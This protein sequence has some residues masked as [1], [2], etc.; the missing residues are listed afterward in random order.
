MYFSDGNANNLN[1]SVGRAV[2]APP[3]SQSVLPARF[4]DSAIRARYDSALTTP[5][6]ARHWRSADPL[7]ADAAMNF[8]VRK[9]I[10][11]RAR[12]EIANNTY[13]KGLVLTFASDIIGTGPRIQLRSPLNSKLSPK[14][15]TR[16][17][18]AFAEWAEETCLAEKLT[19]L[20]QAKTGDGEAFGLMVYNPALESPVKFELVPIECD[21]ITASFEMNSRPNCIDG[22]IIDNIGN[23]VAYEYMEEHPGD[24][25]STKASL[26]QWRRVDA[27]WVVHWFRKDRPE[28]HRGISEIAPALPLFAQL[29]RYTLATIAAAETAADYAA[30]LYTDNPAT[31]TAVKAVPFDCVEIAK[32]T[33]TVL[34]DGWKMGQFNPEQP[35]TTYAEFKREVLGEIARC[36]QVPVNVISGDSSH[37]NYAS[38]RLDHQTYHRAIRVN[39]HQC[40]R[41]VLNKLFREWIKEYSLSLGQSDR[42]FDSLK[43]EWFF[44][45]FEH[46][47]PKKEADAQ[48]VRLASLTT[49]LAR[50]YAKQGL[51][52][53]VELEQIARERAKMKELGIAMEEAVPNV[54]EKE[55]E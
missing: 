30:I 15:E 11:E 47:D 39:Q 4:S 35:V 53:E 8:Q 37:H 22:V 52:W 24:T 28:Q 12:Y 20:A 6:N 54:Q 49:G 17:E 42:K 2:L 48:A 16:I 5:E 55:D 34:P 3:S 9:T 10:R 25:S 45:G 43:A 50:E 18:T 33:M 46:V 26:A 51:D 38:G 44:D 29:R 36:L 32:R 14:W 13:A 19:T 31:Q 23:P 1:I 41:V 21:R 40:A 27:R 7:S